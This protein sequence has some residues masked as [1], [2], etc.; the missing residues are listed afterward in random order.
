MGHFG[1]WDGRR[2]LYDA[3]VDSRK[4]QILELHKPDLIRILTEE[5]HAKILRPL[6]L[7]TNTVN[8]TYSEAMLAS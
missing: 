8:F 3:V 2:L 6:A 5:G 7:K 4:A 1:M